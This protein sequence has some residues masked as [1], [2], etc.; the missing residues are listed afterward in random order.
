MFHSNWRFVFQY[1]CDHDNETDPLMFKSER[2]TA[3]ALCVLSVLSVIY[4]IPFAWYSVKLLFSILTYCCT[5][6]IIEEVDEE[7]LDE[8][9]GKE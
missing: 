3:L 7:D 6:E 8:A 9:D 1:F 5:Y 2:F 4:G